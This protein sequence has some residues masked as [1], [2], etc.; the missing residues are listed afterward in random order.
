MLDGVKNILIF[1]WNISEYHM[2]SHLLCFFS[3]FLCSMVVTRRGRKKHF[4]SFFLQKV[5]ISEH[6]I[7]NPVRCR[8]LFR[9]LLL[10]LTSSIISILYFIYGLIYYIIIKKYLYFLSIEQNFNLIKIPF[11]FYLLLLIFFFIF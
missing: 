1:F 4:K 2:K 3:V 6:E 11:M 8:F 5:G 10:N 9:F 7:R